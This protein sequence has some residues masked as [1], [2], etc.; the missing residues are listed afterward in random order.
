MKL[1]LFTLTSFFIFQI[2]VGQDSIRTVRQYNYE[3]PKT[4][5]DSFVYYKIPNSIFISLDEGFEDSVYVTVNNRPFLNKRLQTNESIGYADGF[6]ITF[7]DSSEIF[8]LKIVFINANRYIHEKVN[9][10]FKFLQIRGF[11]SWFLNY[12]NNC[13]MRE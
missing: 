7:K 4:A 8:D 5:N 11:S 2:T 12:S 3:K 6:R 1:L 9:L 13:P 10:S